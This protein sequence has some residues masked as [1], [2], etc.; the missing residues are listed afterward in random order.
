MSNQMTTMARSN[1]ADIASTVSNLIQGD[2][3]VFKKTRYVVGPG[4]SGDMAGAILEALD[5]IQ[6]W[7]R[8]DKGRVV[9]AIVHTPG[10][11]L[12]LRETLGYLDQSEW[13]PDVGGEPRDPW[14]SPFYLYLFDPETAKDFTFSTA[15]AGGQPPPP[16][17]FS[18]VS[19]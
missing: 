6:A 7:V 1:F 3:I 17:L 5:I 12:P 11:P 16:S 4:R 15:S 14:V 13:E 10:V 9:E 18:V 8:F 19:H 2:L